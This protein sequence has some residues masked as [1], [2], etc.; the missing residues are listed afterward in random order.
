[1]R[2]GAIMAFE[3]VS[4]ALHREPAFADALSQHATQVE[5]LAYLK[6]SLPTALKMLPRRAVARGNAL[7]VVVSTHANATKLY[8]HQTT[9]LSQLA[10]KGYEFSEIRVIVQANVI[11]QVPA[12]NVKPKLGADAAPA[13]DRA[14]RDSTN[15][16][17]KIV[18]ARL[19][20]RAED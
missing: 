2:T 17:L 8:Q 20:A 6:A 11:S 19:R 9:A 5:L 1:M 13:F 18:L 10:T 7:H 14:I 15:E 16:K 4:R 12:G 3:P